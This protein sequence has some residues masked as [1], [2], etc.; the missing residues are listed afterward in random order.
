MTEAPVKVIVNCETGEST[1]I[2]LT[3]KE[4]AEMEASRAAHEDLLVQ[5][6]AEAQAKAEAK[7]SAF[8]KLEALGLTEEEA[9]ALIS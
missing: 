8:A 9:A 2:P 7:A 4:I 3:A 5:R 1:T 6:E